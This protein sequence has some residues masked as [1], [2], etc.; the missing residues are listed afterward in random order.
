MIPAH[1]GGCC[2]LL[3]YCCTCKYS[4]YIYHIIWWR[5]WSCRTY[6]YLRQAQQAA[7]LFSFFNY[8]EDIHMYLHTSWSKYL[9]VPLSSAGNKNGTNSNKRHLLSNKRYLSC[10]SST[11]LVTRKKIIK[12]CGFCRLSVVVVARRVLPPMPM[13]W[14]CTSKLDWDT[15]SMAAARA[16]AARDTLYYYVA[17]HVSYR[18]VM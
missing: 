8:F 13:Y 7:L 1:H 11:L 6:S 10:C 3:L 16:A 15:S 4:V 2:C 18:G 17:H 12:T 9:F 14:R 5:W